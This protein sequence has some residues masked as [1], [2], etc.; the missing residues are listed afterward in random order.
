VDA[1]GVDDAIQRI[2]EPTRQM[3][4]AANSS[5]LKVVQDEAQKDAATA[6]AMTDRA[7]PA[8]LEAEDDEPHE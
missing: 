6:Q 5:W 7:I 8:K 2:L 1:A 3:I 4:A